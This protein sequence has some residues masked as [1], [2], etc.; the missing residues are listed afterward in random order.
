MAEQKRCKSCGALIMWAKNERTGRA[1]PID[2]VPDEGGNVLMLD[3]DED[4]VWYRV[5]N[6]EQRDKVNEPLRTS[7]FQ[8]CP[9]ANNW[10]GGAHAS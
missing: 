7:H 4:G 6:K 8:T 2:V 1:A 10:K 5:L 9:Q 3:P